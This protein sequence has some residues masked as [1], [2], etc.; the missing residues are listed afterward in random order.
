MRDA[1]GQGTDPWGPYRPAI[2]DHV[3]ACA[4][5][6]GRLHRSL[7]GEIASDRHYFNDKAYQLQ[8]VAR[9]LVRLGQDIER[10]LNACNASVQRDVEGFWGLAACERPAGHTGPHDDDP[11]RAPAERLCDEARGLTDLNER[12]S[13]SIGWLAPV[14]DQR[15]AALDLLEPEHHETLHEFASMLDR[16]AHDARRL[17]SRVRGLGL[18]Q[19]GNQVASAST[20]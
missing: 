3:A 17:A 18:D 5:Y 9:A 16:I 4:D 10:W 7:A 1:N 12:V 8:E 15:N 19:D 2:E 11:P 20:T 13:H 14:V 6:L